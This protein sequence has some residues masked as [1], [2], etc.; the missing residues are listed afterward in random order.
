MSTIYSSTVHLSEKKKKARDF[1]PITSASLPPTQSS[2]HRGSLIRHRM[3]LG[4]HDLFQVNPHLSL[5]TTTSFLCTAHQL[6]NNH[7]LKNIWPERDFLV[8]YHLNFANQNQWGH[9]F[10][11]V[12][13]QPHARNDDPEDVGRNPSDKLSW[14]SAHPSPWFCSRQNLRTSGLASP[15]FLILPLT[16]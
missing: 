11:L 9:F 6:F 10:H 3:G 8:N 1:L 13:I 12:A 16:R 2:T 15:H 7:F 4:W 5:V 14:G